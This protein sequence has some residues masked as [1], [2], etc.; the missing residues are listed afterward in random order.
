MKNCPFEGAKVFCYLG[1]TSTEFT[2]DFLFDFCK[3]SN[4]KKFP[5]KKKA[6]DFLFILLE[7]GSINIKDFMLGIE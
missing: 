7:N 4:H 1:R 6:R 2:D 3:M 5:C